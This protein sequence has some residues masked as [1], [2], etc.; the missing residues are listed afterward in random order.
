MENSK[1]NETFTIVR[2][3]TDIHYDT[4]DQKFYEGNWERTQDKKEY[5]E[6]LIQNDPEKFEDCTIVTSEG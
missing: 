1:N 6:Q 2:K 4:N 3:G 5:L